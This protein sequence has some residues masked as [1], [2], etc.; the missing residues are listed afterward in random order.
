V[1]QVFMA[2]GIYFIII[3]ITFLFIRGLTIAGRVDKFL[4]NY[5]FFG[6]NLMKK[7]LHFNA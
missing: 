3:I 7:K 6:E 1:K 5:F 4:V 2:Q